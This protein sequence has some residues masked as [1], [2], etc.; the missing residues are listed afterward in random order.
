MNGFMLCISKEDNEVYR[1]Y[2]IVYPKT[3]FP[4]FLYYDG[5]QWRLRSAKYFI[6]LD[7]IE[8]ID[9]DEFDEDCGDGFFQDGE[10]G[11]DSTFSYGG[12][13]IMG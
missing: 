12:F 9:D 10:D 1:I 6:P 11:S 8:L 13:D 5:L 7:E 4:N 3:G 2:D